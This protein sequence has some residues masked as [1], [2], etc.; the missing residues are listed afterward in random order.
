[1]QIT[2][3]S[4]PWTRPTPVMIPARQLQKRR[5]AIEQRLDPVTGKQLAA[6][7]VALG[8]PGSSA[9]TDPC[10]LGAQVVGQRRVAR[11]VGG[12]LVAGGVDVAAQDDAHAISSSSTS[13]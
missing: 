13:A 5:A 11:G 8:C 3:T 1:L 2:I 12:E 7:E 9:G 4:R 10:P 6:G